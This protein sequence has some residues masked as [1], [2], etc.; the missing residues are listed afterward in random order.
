MATNYLHIPAVGQLDEYAC[1]AA[2]LKWWYKAAKN[3]K[4][5]QTKLIGK[6]NYLTDDF[7]AMSDDA[8]EFVIVDNDMYPH[9]LS[10]ASAFTAAELASML[11]FGPVYCAYTETSTQKKHCNVI[12]ELLDAGSNAPRVRVMEPQHIQNDDLTYRGEHQLKPLSDFN[13][14]G[15]VYCGYK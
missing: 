11:R 1:W 6:Y 5:S 13:R 3:L 14:F 7:G 9:S 15:S 10:N 4:K 2:C 12:Y 8:I